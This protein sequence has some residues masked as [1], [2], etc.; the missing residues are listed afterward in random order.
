[1]LEFYIAFGALAVFALIFLRRYLKIENGKLFKPLSFGKGS[2]FHHEDKAGNFEI[3][4]E[5]MIPPVE[6]VDAKSIAKSEL[7][8]KKAEIQL[9]RGDMKSAEKIL[10][11]ALA[12]NPAAVEAYN[13]LGM[14][15]LRQEKF[16]KAENIFRKLILTISDEAAFFSNLGLALYRQGKLEE[17]TGH[18]KKAIDLDNSRAGRFFSLAQIFRE[19]GE[20]E[21]AL[22][23]LR[24]AVLMEPKNLDYLITLAEFYLESGFTQE[25]G[26]LLDEIL[27]IDP[28][29]EMALKMRGQIQG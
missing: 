4:I 22:S 8:L 29:N 24:Q 19:L 1:M 25:A 7:L 14:I 10:I 27:F 28:K 2:F 13:K 5:E 9:D 15:Y 26:G 12:L 6:K 3:T 16:N 17:A 18:Y 20:A 23:H 11:Q 21:S